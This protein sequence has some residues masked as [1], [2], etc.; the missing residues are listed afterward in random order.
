MVSIIFSKFVFEVGETAYVKIKYLPVGF[1]KIMIV[2][3][4]NGVV[5]EYQF[6]NL[7]QDG[8]FPYSFKITQQMIGSNNFIVQ[9]IYLWWYEN[10]GNNW[11]YVNPPKE[12]DKHTEG[13][14]TPTV[15]ISSAP[16]VFIILLLLL[17]IAIARR[18]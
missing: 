11:F 6:L 13:D 2:N 5:H 7:N 9:R 18:K 1:I 3:D 14:K 16:F 8:E 15:S 10:L 4:K 17:V 12:G